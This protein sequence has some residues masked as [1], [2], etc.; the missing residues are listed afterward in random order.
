MPHTPRF[1][2]ASEVL[3]AAS[4]ELQN[5]FRLGGAAGAATALSW[6]PSAPGLPPLLLVGTAAA[7]AQVWWYQQQLM[8]W[9]LAA[10][11]GDTQ[12]RR[13]WP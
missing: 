12:V 13:Q 6:R 2:E 1:F 8:R 5:H 3:A 10:T 11:L 9:Q 4:W 7:G